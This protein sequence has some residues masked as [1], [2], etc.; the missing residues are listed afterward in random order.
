MNAMLIPLESPIDFGAP[1]ARFSVTVMPE[2]YSDAAAKAFRVRLPEALHRAVP[3]RKAEYIAGRFCAAR[4]IEALGGSG[5]D[6]EI[7]SSPRGAPVWPD[8]LVGSITHTRGFASAVIARAGDMR[9]LGIDSERIM[10]EVVMR[11]IEATICRPEER[12]VPRGAL[13]PAVYATLVFSAKE[14]VF[15]CI[16]PLVRRMFWFEHARIEIADPGEGAFRATLFI[17][18]DDEFRT[19]TVLEGRYRV[20]PPFVHT[21]VFLAAGRQPRRDGRLIDRNPPG[22]SS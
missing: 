7:R 4:A 9:S 3:R 14:S 1:V 11:D 6:G 12:G 2:T 13:S 8:G 15:K 20:M 18:F 17:D 16:Y 21:G 19:G 10:T 5:F 22:S